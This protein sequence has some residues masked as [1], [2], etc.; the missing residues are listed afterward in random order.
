[1]GTYTIVAASVEDVYAAGLIDRLDADIRSRYPGEP[2]NG[3]DPQQFRA[4]GGYFAGARLD[5][6]DPS[7]LVGC[8]AFRPFDGATVEIKR[9]FVHP[10]HRGRGVARAILAALEAEARRRGF[11]RAILE[12]GNRQTEAI[13]LYQACGYDRIEP[14]GQYVGDPKSLC[15]GKGL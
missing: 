10:A 7:A 2:V 4:A 12:T 3:I 13:A 11:T 9:M 5:G 15:F 6:S 1:M 8:G 14:F